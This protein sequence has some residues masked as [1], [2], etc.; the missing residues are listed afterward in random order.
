MQSNKSQ[1]LAALMVALV[2]V[3]AGCAAATF[4]E[5]D[6]ADAHATEMVNLDNAGDK[7][8]EGEHE[9]FE[10]R[11]ISEIS[12][13]WDCTTMGNKLCVHPTIAPTPR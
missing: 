9:I 4:A 2:V 13:Y 6:E 7:D 10:G 11:R 1:P 8:G 3:L 12:I 5:K